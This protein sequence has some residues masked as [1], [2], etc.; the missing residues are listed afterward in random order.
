MARFRLNTATFIAPQLYPAGT[1]IEYEGAVGPHM[2]PVD[3]AGRLALETYYRENPGASLNPTEGLSRTMDG[4]LPQGASAVASIVSLPPKDEPDPNQMTLGMKGRAVDQ[5]FEIVGTRVEKAP[6]IVGTDP[7]DDK[8]GTSGLA[9]PG[10]AAAPG[11]DPDKAQ[12][13]KD[14]A[15]KANKDSA[16]ETTE[17]KVDIS[18]LGVK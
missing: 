14:A 6:A 12:E 5:D 16:K 7:A 9:T 11:A 3:E 2:D 4:A 13:V 1:V 15:A 17:D 10:D 8:V 18:K